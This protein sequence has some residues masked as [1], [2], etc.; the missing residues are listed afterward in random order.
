M[1]RYVINLDRSPDRWEH[2]QKQLSTIGAQHT[3]LKIQ[4][5]AGV[6]GSKLTGNEISSH[7]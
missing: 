4:R 1:E 6:D 2:M 3:S 7:Q 5:V